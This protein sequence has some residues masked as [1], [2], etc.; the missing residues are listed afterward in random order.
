MPLRTGLLKPITTGQ[1]PPTSKDHVGKSFWAARQ[2]LVADQ[3]DSIGRCEVA[4]IDPGRQIAVT[5]AVSRGSEALAKSSLRLL[6]VAR[7]QPS[8]AHRR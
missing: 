8:K 7:Q 3:G 6:A 4:I 1:G 2:T 5:E